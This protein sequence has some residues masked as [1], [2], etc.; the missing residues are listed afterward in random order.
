ME[1]FSLSWGDVEVTEPADGPTLGL[2]VGMGVILL[3]LLAETKS[4][5]T[6][7]ADIVLSYLCASGLCLGTW[8]GRHRAL[9]PGV[10][11]GDPII[12]GRSGRAWD[13]RYFRT[14]HVY[15]WLRA[16]R[17][18]GSHRDLEAFTEAPGNRLEDKFY[19]MGMYRRGGKSSA[20]KRRDGTFRASELEVYE[21]G[22]WKHRIATES[23]AQRYNQFTLED[24][25]YITRCCM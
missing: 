6:R 16:M 15:P 3:R 8:M 19:S 13:S 20:A 21:H 9:W 11:V 24:R 10:S 18:S 4:N 22:R 1:L 5:R 23:M 12:R 25:V 7:V 14:V 17:A 2:P